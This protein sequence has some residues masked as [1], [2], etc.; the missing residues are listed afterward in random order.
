MN[1]RVHQNLHLALLSW[2]QFQNIRCDSIIEATVLFT[3]RLL[4]KLQQKKKKGLFWEAYELF[5]EAC[6]PELKPHS[7]KLHVKRQQCS[8]SVKHGK[9][10]YS[11]FND[12]AP[13][14]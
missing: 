5:N 13:K 2:K 14:C 4:M 1:T 9:G 11:V 3:K 7:G 10:A 6:Q 8:A 12:K